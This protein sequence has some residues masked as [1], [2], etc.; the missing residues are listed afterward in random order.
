M[1]KENVLEL[2]A[3]ASTHPRLK[4]Q[5]EAATSFAELVELGKEQGLAFSSDQVKDAIADVAV[6]KPG[7]LG[8]IAQAVLE[9]FKPSSDNYPISGVQP[10]TGDPNK[11]QE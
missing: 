2:F 10:F 9:I 11:N 6:K 8:V 3:R 4:S 7:F 1:S 5:L